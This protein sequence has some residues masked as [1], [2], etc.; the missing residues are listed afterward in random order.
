MT[1][2]DSTVMHAGPSEAVAQLEP[3]YPRVYSLNRVGLPITIRSSRKFYE[4]DHRNKSETVPLEFSACLEPPLSRNAHPDLPWPSHAEVSMHAKCD[5]RQSLNSRD[6]PKL[7]CP[8]RPGFVLPDPT[9]ARFPGPARRMGAKQRRGF[10]NV[11]PFGSQGK[12]P[13]MRDN[14]FMR[15]C[16]NTTKYEFSCANYSL[17]TLRISIFIRRHFFLQFLQR[18]VVCR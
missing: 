2:P 18:M 1:L 5:T 12:T 16:V 3:D 11:N 7:R 14:A 6:L 9:Q 15:G 4:I 8:P 10:R 17:R 13:A